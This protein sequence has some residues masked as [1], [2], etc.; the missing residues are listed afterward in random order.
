MTLDPVSGPSTSLPD[1]IRRR[2]R[3]QHRTGVAEVVEIVGVR[4]QRDRRSVDAGH[5]ERHQDHL[6]FR[7]AA[8]QSTGETP[9]AKL[10]DSVPA[11]AGD[12]TVGGERTAVVLPSRDGAH[13]G[14]P[15]DRARRSDRVALPTVADLTEH[16][17]APATGAPIVHGRAGVRC[18]DRHR[19]RAGQRRR[20][21]R[22]IATAAHPEHDHGHQRPDNPV[23]PHRSASI[24]RRR[25]SSSQLL[26]C[27]NACKPG[28][29][30]DSGGIQEPRCVRSH[31]TGAPGRAKRYW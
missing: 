3:T 5:R 9:V 11:P 22:R 29:S 14:D 2:S 6:L 19:D 13:A 20:A 4:D 18:A 27:I 1:G 7:R 16:V 31:H 17:E 26:R 25:H 10:A 15:H 23:A 24:A 12:A 28:S 8:R 21:R 30:R